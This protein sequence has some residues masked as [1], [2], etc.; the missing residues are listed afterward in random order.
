V[1]DY[2]AMSASWERL[3]ADLEAFQPDLV[4][5]NVTA[6]T[7]DADLGAARLTRELFPQTLTIACGEVFDRAGETPSGKLPRVGSGAVRRTGS[8][9]SDFGGIARGPGIRFP[10][11]GAVRSRLAA[12]ALARSRGRRGRDPTARPRPRRRPGHAPPARA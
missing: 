3:R 2:P 6:A 11:D 9:V 1:G 7:A 12:I 4:L 5:F 8:D 10:L